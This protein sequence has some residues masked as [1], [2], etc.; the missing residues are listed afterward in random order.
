[1]QYNI[2]L[3]NYAEVKPKN[4]VGSEQNELKWVLSDSVSSN[5]QEVAQFPVPVIRGIFSVG[6]SVPAS[7][8]EFEEHWQSLNPRN[9]THWLRDFVQDSK[10]CRFPGKSS[11]DTT[12]IKLNC[13]SKYLHL[14]FKSI[15]SDETAVHRLSWSLCDFNMPPISQDN[16]YLVP[17]LDGVYAYA[18]ALKEAW[19]MKCQNRPGLCPQMVQMNNQVGPSYFQV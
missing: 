19:R 7:I 1:M 18:L 6:A 17:L 8:P 15:V 13:F 9:A 5:I 3:Q 11:F 2:L 16:T 10:R 12:F 4:S 14:C